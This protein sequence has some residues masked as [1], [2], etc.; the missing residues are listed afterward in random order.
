MSFSFLNFF[1]P[2]KEIPRISKEQID[3]KYPILRWRILEATFIGYA[4]FYIV[5]NNFPIVS[6]EMAE[7]LNYSQEQVG[8]ILSITAISY[9]IGKFLMGAL[10]DR[11]NPKVFMPIG[12][13]LTAICN[14]LFGG[15]SD[16]NTHLTLWGLNGLFQGMGWPPCGRSLGH[17]FGVSERGTKFAIWNIAHNVGGGLVGVI[18][19]YSTSWFGWRNAF[20]IPAGISVVTAIYLFFRLLDTPQSVGLPPIEEYQEKESFSTAEIE[21]LEKELGFREIIVESVLKNPKI[22]LFAL[23]NF[24]VYI[25]RYGLTDW[26]PSYLKFTKGA[27]V[28]KGGIS[29]LIYEFAAIGS[30][31]YIGRISDN[32]GGKRGIASL[33]CLFPILFALVGILFVPKGKLWIDL[34]LFGIVGLLIYPPV[35]LL[36]VAGLDFTSKKAV[37]TAAGF[38]GLFGYLG[39]TALSQIVGKLSSLATFQWEFLIY[40]MLASGMIAILLLSIT[41]NWKPKA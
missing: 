39:R 38:I 35:M 27:G 15:S 37:G 36:G 14:I 1:A 17:W 26:G 22:W 10:S 33:L 31:L 24:F 8:N 13:L 40:L 23:A 32:L 18:A 3:Q 2:A 19:A 5:R 41:W 4:V 6:K 12:L 7:A 11:S 29:T 21:S 9:G 30:T 25:V 16:Y 20:F 28:E 34:T